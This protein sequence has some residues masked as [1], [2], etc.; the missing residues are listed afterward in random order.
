MLSMKKKSLFVCFAALALLLA[1][2]GCGGGSTTPPPT[3]TITITNAPV[4]SFYS[5]TVFEAGATITSAT[6]ETL[7]DTGLRGYEFQAFG[8]GN[9]T[10][11]ISFT[12]SEFPDGNYVLVLGGA[13]SMN[14]TEGEMYITGTPG[15]PPTRKA[16]AVD[17][18][19]PINFT[20]DFLDNGGSGYE[21]EDIPSLFGSP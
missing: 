9:T 21:L 4:R 19:D 5:L 10:S 14:G 6:R 7:M 20:A 8:Y 18:S 15:T 16:V 13:N 3:V 17:F 12:F 1:F 11:T 2:S